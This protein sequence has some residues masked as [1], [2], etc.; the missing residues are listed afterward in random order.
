[1]SMVHSSISLSGL[2]QLLWVGGCLWATAWC[3]VV[4]RP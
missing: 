1:L 2:P 3:I 4:A